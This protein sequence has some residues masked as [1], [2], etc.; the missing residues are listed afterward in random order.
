VESSDPPHRFWCDITLWHV[1]IHIKVIMIIYL[2][3]LN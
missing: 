2:R 3:E 1:T